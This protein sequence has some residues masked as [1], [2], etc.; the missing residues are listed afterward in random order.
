MG[1]G[2]KNVT[3]LPK[4]SF[5]YHFRGKETQGCL[6]LVFKVGGLVVWS[7]F[8]PRLGSWACDGGRDF[9]FTVPTTGG[10]EAAVV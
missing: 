4:L 3:L 7:L 5:L 2:V 8:L 10:L 6:K 1:R 9:L